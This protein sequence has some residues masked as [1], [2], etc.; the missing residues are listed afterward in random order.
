MTAAECIEHV[1][2]LRPQL[3][4]FARSR[5]SNPAH[6]EDAVQEAL[7]AA[8]ESIGSFS[9]NSTL[10]S[11][12]TGILRHKIVDCVRR[13]ARDQWLQI[14]GEGTPFDGDEAFYPPT[15]SAPAGPEQAL[16][17][18]QLWGAVLHCMQD[19]PERTAETFVLREFVGMNTAEASRALAVTETNC[20]VMLHRARARIREKLAPVW[21]ES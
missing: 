21:T 20:A 3:V 12:L 10:Y 5:L 19:L 17:R 8:I 2:K 18:R 4:R 15:A 6:A 7:L 1:G 16:A 14:D 9:G 11:W 13:S